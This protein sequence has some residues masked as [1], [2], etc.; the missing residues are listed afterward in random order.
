M[1]Q[2]DGA[3]TVVIPTIGRPSL[4]NALSSVYAQTY[5]PYEVIVCN[6]SGRSLEL[7]EYNNIRIVDVGPGAGGNNARIAG[8]KEASGDYVAL[9]DDD[10]VWTPSHL[11]RLYSLIP[12]DSFHGMWIA[13]S[14]GL[15]ADGAQYPVREKDKSESLSQYLFVLKGFS[16][17]SKGALS[18]STLMFPSAL[19]KVVP[20][21][22]SV[23]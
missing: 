21:R 20:D 3:I 2:H 19:T 15:L 18:T 11:E 10:D 7:P 17:T 5:P 14:T 16:S 4:L 1:S 6:D 9:L 8:M 13:S 12:T 23:V 22:K